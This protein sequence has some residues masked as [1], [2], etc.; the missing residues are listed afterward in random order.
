MP[1]RTFSRVSAWLAT[2]PAT[3]QAVSIFFWLLPP[4]ACAEGVDESCWVRFLAFACAPTATS[5]Q[6][7]IH[8]RRIRVVFIERNYCRKTQTLYDTTLPFLS[9]TASYL[10]MLDSPEMGSMTRSNC[11]C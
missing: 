9:G 5:A 3:M 4:A 8:M 11:A 2:P 10:E 6:A 1:C 7:T